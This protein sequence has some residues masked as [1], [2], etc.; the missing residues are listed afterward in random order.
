MGVIGDYINFS[1]LDKNN[2]IEAENQYE[3]LGGN[4][5]DQSTAPANIPVSPDRAVIELLQL[6]RRTS[7]RLRLGGVYQ[8]TSSSQFL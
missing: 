8:I 6:L 5:N 3:L 4:P 2:G 1:F 7:H